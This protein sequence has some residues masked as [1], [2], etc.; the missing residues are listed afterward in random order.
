[1]SN[2][3]DQLI[4]IDFSRKETEAGW[5]RI[6]DNLGKNAAP[7][8]FNWLA[9]ILIIAAFQYLFHKSRTIVLVPI[10][11]I[12]VG[13]FWLHLQAFFYRLR[14]RNWPILRHWD[15]SRVPSMLVSAFLA[16]G[17]W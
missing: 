8:W 14:F 6:L 7:V 5:I 10:L 15:S 13:L 12:S 11:V 16:W 17:C 2:D 9:W 4:E 3:D 1:M